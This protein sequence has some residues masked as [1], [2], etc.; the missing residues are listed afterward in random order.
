MNLSSHLLNF[1]RELLEID[2][3][4]DGLRFQLHG[5]ISNVNFSTKKQIFLLFIN[6]RLV[7]SAGKFLL[8]TFLSFISIINWNLLFILSNIV[9]LTNQNKI[10]VIILTYYY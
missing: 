10:L 2:Y 5:F 3:V 9:I 4:D 1:C 8:N 6:N 7:D